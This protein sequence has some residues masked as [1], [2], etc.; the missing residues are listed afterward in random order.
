M[1]PA[2]DTVFSE[3]EIPAYPLAIIALPGAEEFAEKVDKYL[4]DWYGKE[5]A[6]KTPASFIVPTNFPRFTSGDGKAMILDSVRGKDLYVVIDTGNHGVQYKMFGQMQ[7]MSPDDHFQNLKRLIS[8]VGGKASRITVVMPLLYGGR[9]HRRNARE[10]LDCAIMLRELEVMGVKDLITFDAHDP[11]VQNAVPLMGFDNFFPCYQI[12]KAVVRKYP[13]IVFD[14]EHTMII[15]PDEGAMS[16]NIYYASVLGLDLGMF[17]KRRDFSVVINGRNPIVAHEYIGNPVAGK[18]IL[19]AD[20]IIATGDSMLHL[21]KD[22]KDKGA[23]RIILV[24]TFAMFTEGTERFDKAYAEGIFDGVIST[25]L[26]YTL[27]ELSE[28]EWFSKAELS[29][30]MAYIISACNHNASVS[31]LL[32]PHEKIHDLLRRHNES[33][34]KTNK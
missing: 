7:C 5:C 15:S 33:L 28:R 12:L 3:D 9:Q 11:R 13:D 17:Y 1:T 27:P 26:S 31:G 21:A 4:V 25:N 32:D 23:R 14:K 22:L 10:S 30:Y 8:A 6:K 20:D 16:R 19:V 29:K 2:F 34:N 18:D 24:P